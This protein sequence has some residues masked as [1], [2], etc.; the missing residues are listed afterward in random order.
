MSDNIEIKNKI[1]YAFSCYL[2][3]LG[4]NMFVLTNTWAVNRPNGALYEIYRNANR[5]VGPVPE[6]LPGSSGFRPGFQ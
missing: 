6:V 3:Y 1:K 2:S 4:Y 5:Y